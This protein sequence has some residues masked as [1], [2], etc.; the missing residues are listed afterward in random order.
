LCNAAGE[1]TELDHG[2]SDRTGDAVLSRWRDALDVVVA[3]DGD[4]S[5]RYVAYIELAA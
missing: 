4:L 1:V 3:V 2:A 5:P